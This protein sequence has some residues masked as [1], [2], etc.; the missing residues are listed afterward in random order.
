MLVSLLV[1]KNV[2]LTEVLKKIGERKGEHLSENLYVFKPYIKPKQSS[3]FTVNDKKSINEVIELNDINNLNVFD[4]NTKVCN[5]HTLEL[6]L[7]ERVDGKSRIKKSERRLNTKTVSGPYIEENIGL[8][9]L[10]EENKK[11]YE[12]LFN[13]ITASKYRVISLYI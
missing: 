4:M 7:M 9:H 3:T 2:E 12:Y 1:D 8:T 6:E 13:D 11:D 5:L 10:I